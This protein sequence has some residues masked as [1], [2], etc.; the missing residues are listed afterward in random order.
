MSDPYTDREMNVTI[1]VPESKRYAGDNPWF[2]FRGS[3]EAVREMLIEAFDLDKD[4]DLFAAVLNAQRIATAGGVL[5]GK[6]ISPGKAADTS[7]ADAAWQQAQSS[8]E[9]GPPWNAEEKK[10]E[11]V[12]PILAGIESSTDVQELQRLWA[13]N[14]D[15]FNNNTAYMDAYKAK[16]RALSGK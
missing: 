13:E 2:V 1:K 12:D 16:G 5:G 4:L 9:Q 7:G 8:N 15:A 14:Q 11:E 6:V 10:A 3:P